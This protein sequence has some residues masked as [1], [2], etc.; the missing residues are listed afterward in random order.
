[1]SLYGRE[2]KTDSGQ[3]YT[4]TWMDAYCKENYCLLL[5]RSIGPILQNKSMLMSK[6]FLKFHI[7]LENQSKMSRKLC[8]IVI[9]SW[10][11]KIKKIKPRTTKKRQ[12][13]PVLQLCAF[14]GRN[15]GSRGIIE[16]LNFQVV[17]LML[18]KK[19]FSYPKVRH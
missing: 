3:G 5:I 18:T 6:L 10:T 4:D 11:I 17:S 9:V 1:M 14:Y 7:L 19:T 8:E 12:P 2:N 13:E 16:T 15:S